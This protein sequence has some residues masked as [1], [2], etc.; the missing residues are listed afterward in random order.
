MP[1]HLLNLLD[2][3][4]A[5]LIEVL[6][7]ADQMKRLRGRLDHRVGRPAKHTFQISKLQGRD[8]SPRRPRIECN[9]HDCWA[10]PH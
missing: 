9:V 1:R 2:L 6:D 8:A 7:L 3:G 5:G 4:P 10:V